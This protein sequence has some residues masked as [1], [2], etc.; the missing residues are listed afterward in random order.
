MEI[1][2]ALALGFI[3]GILGGM[4]GIG[5]GWIVIPG[6]VLLLG[7]EQHTAQGVSLSVIMIIAAAGSMAHWRQG[8]I[9]MS[10]V[11]G[12]VPAAVVFA[13]LGGWG[14]G[15]VSAPVLTRIFGAVLLLIGAE[16]L[17]GLSEKLRRGPSVNTN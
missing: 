10:L 3:S 16:M 6:M 11:A 4:F 14:A 13:L 8:T 9:R 5:G 2:I 7:A 12:I 1:A 17:F 15:F